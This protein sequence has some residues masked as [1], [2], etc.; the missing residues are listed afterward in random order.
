[1]FSMKSL[2]VTLLVF[3]SFGFNKVVPNDGLSYIK[4]NMQEILKIFELYSG[5]LQIKL[6]LEFGLMS[7]EIK[8]AKYPT[9]DPKAITVCTNKESTINILFELSKNPL[10]QEGLPN[11]LYQIKS[12]FSKIPAIQLE[13]AEIQLINGKDVVVIEFLS[14]AIDGKIY[15][16]MFIT[17]IDGYTFTSNFNCT[18]ENMAEWKPIGKQIL[19]SLKEF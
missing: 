3:I 18:I 14:E 4:V 19:N 9:S 17:D 10:Q 11:I 6:P 12:E 7:E 8:K 2:I 5:R 16:L 15:N 1:M 13:N